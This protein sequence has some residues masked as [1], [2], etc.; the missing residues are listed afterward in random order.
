MLIANL[1]LRVFLVGHV[2]TNEVPKEHVC[3]I[4]QHDLVTTCTVAVQHWC[5][6]DYSFLL[7][8]HCKSVCHFY[9]SKCVCSI[10]S[11]RAICCASKF[12]TSTCSKIARTTPHLCCRLETC[13]FEAKR[14]SAL[15]F[16]GGSVHKIKNQLHWHA[17]CKK[18]RWTVWT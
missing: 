1:W 11:N 4:L 15:P 8:R 13:V 14:R 17:E 10:L 2:S 16:Q 6:D 9:Q 3:L 5:I 12:S 7:L 18:Q